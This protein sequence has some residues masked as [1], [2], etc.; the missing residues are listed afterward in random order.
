METIIE[1][2]Q[3]DELD[4]ITLLD[5][6]QQEE[7]MVDQVANKFGLYKVGIIFTD[8]TDAGTKNGKVLCK[9]HK[10]SYFLTNLNILIYLNIVQQRIMVNFHQN[11]LLVSYRVD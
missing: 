8:L 3:H 6:D 9:R 1:P 11:L 7:K 5:W 10:D 2:P 4:G